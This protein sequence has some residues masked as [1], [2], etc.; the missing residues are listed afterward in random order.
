MPIQRLVED[1]LADA[2]ARGLSPK[3]IKDAYG[4]LCDFLS[5]S[6]GRRRPSR[7]CQGAGAPWQDGQTTG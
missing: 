6:E 7:G 3:T 4:G 5:D 2:R 1:Y